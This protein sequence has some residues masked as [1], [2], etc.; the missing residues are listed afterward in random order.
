ML[1]WEIFKKK[2]NSGG[3]LNDYGFG[4]FKPRND[5]N[6]E[7]LHSANADT[8]REIGKRYEEEIV[9]GAFCVYDVDDP[10]HEYYIARVK[11]DAI[12]AEE[13]MEF[14]FGKEKFSV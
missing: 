14:E 6:E 10:N 12:M 5:C 4:H 13:D 7:E 2:D 9:D 3:G 11:G 8:L 1:E